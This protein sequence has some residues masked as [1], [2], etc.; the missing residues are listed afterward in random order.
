MNFLQIGNRTL[1]LDR[2]S[3]CEVQIWHDTMSVKIFLAGM[4][5][6]TPVVLNEA[7]A[8]Q[9]WTYMESVAQKPA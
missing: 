6:N 1:N 5:N 4:A 7:E 9:F 3:Y 2:I 8:K